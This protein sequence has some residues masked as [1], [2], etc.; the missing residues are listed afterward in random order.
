MPLEVLVFEVD[1]VALGVAASQVQEV[2]RAAALF[3]LPE[4]PEVVEGGLNLRGAIVPVVSGRAAL[5][6]PARPLDPSDHLIVLRG[7]QPI[8]LRVDRAVELAEAPAVEGPRAADGKLVSGVV[9]AAHGPIAVLDAAQLLAL[10]VPASAR[11][12]QE[13]RP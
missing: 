4:R 11:S 13:S 5:G 9:N 3:D 2:L 6:R 7:S 1:G 12:A 8:A 10:A